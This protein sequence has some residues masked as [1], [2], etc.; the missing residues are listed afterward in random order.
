MRSGICFMSTPLGS[1]PLFLSF[2]FETVA[3]PCD[4]SDSTDARALAVRFK[5]FEM[6]CESRAQSLGNFD[7]TKESPSGVR[8]LF[9]LSSFEPGG[10]WSEAKRSGIIFELLQSP[11]TVCRVLV[12]F[13]MQKNG[14]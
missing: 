12:N 13:E 11:M 7:M 1:H 2:E 3:R 9:G 4:I 5:S 8:G 6:T 10:I 14:P